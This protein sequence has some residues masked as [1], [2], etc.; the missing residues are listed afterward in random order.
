MSAAIRTLRQTH[1]APITAVHVDRPRN[2]FA[3]LFELLRTDSQSYLKAAENVFALAVGGSFYEQMLPTAHVSLG[4]CSIALHWLSRVPSTPGPTWP[5]MR[6]GQD[7]EP[8][9]Q[10][11]ALDWRMF[12]EQRS[13]E[14]RPDSALVVV[15]PASGRH[16][17]WSLAGLAKHV[18]AMLE[19]MAGDGTLHPDEHARMLVPIYDRTLEELRA[20]FADPALGLEL[21]EMSF[22]QVPDPIWESYSTCGDLGALADGYS[23]FV[24]AA[25]GPTLVDALNPTRPSAA[26]PDFLQALAVGL[27]RRVLAEPAMLCAPT[28][29]TMLIVKTSVRGDGHFSAR[30]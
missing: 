26:S 28:V 10:Q 6:T 20:P 17:R 21:E 13:A 24:R 15:V 12:L 11:A 29:A 18:M 14:L 2:D 8:F 22:D 4:W 1:G 19:E 3:S 25:F 5:T 16:G 23:G 27:R 9:V 7:R 30:R